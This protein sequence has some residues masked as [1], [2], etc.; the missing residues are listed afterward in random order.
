MLE[1]FNKFVFFAGDTGKYYFS[2]KG[3]CEE[4]KE[5]GKRFPN[6]NLSLLPIG[7][8]LKIEKK[9]KINYF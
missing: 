6:I 9:V 4:F 8:Y 2:K 1:S 3:Y 5:I 7:I